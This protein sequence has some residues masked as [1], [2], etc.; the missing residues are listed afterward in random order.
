MAVLINFKICD[1]AKECGGIAVCPTGALSWDK[2]NKKIKIDN[3]KCIACGACAGTCPIDAIRVAKNSNEYKKI[4]KEIDADKR[5]ISDLMV[6][7]YGASPIHPFFL[8]KEK[9]FDSSILEQKLTPISVVEFFNDNSIMCLLK[10]IPYKEIINNDK[11]TFR[12]INIADKK[13][14]KKYKITKLPSLLFFKNGKILGKIQGYYGKDK[15]TELKTK[16]SKIL[17][18]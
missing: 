5:K 7:R 9:D 14:L 11:I 4:K 18:K 15:K 17:G 8:I 12:K 2:K 3:K 10:S 1:N 13:L 6:D 16:I